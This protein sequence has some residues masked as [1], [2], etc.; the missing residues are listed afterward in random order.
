MQ[1]KKKRREARRFAESNTSNHPPGPSMDCFVC[2]E[3]CVHLVLNRAQARQITG[4]GGTSTNGHC[5]FFLIVWVRF[6]SVSPRTVLSGAKQKWSQCCT[7]GSQGHSAGSVSCRGALQ[8]EDM[9]QDM[10]S[11]SL[12]KETTT[13]RAS[14]ELVGDRRQPAA[15]P[16]MHRSCTHTAL[17]SQQLF[18]CTP[19]IGTA[20]GQWGFGTSPLILCS[21]C[22]FTA[23]RMG[24][25]T[26]LQSNT[27]RKYPISSMRVG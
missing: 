23:Q 1:Q 3:M 12:S 7:P 14:I 19:T 21:S 10:G 15:A 9:L 5:I 22:A 17:G 16:P 8:Q 27:A 20:G 4:E 24:G 26:Q 11:S 13:K 6:M 2:L 18:S 25:I